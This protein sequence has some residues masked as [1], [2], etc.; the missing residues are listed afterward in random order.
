MIVHDSKNSTIFVMQR[1]ANFCKDL[2][3]DFIMS[4]NDVLSQL[5]ADVL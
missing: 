4:H 2:L 3:T 1:N 5:T